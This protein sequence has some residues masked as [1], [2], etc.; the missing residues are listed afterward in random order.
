[1][2][3]KPYVDSID[4][5][6]PKPYVDPEEPAPIFVPATP[7]EEGAPVETIAEPVQ[8]NA[9]KNPE[10]VVIDQE[11]DAAARSDKSNKC[12]ATYIY[13]AVGIACLLIVGGIV[14]AIVVGISSAESNAVSTSWRYTP[15]PTAAP[16]TNFPT[17]SR[18]TSS[19]SSVVP[20]D[21]GN[22]TEAPSSN[23]TYTDTSTLAPTTP[24]RWLCDGGPPDVAQVEYRNVP[25]CL[26]VQPRST[27]MNLPVREP[28]RPLCLSGEESLS[29]P[30]MWCYRDETADTFQSY[31][32]W[33]SPCTRCGTAWRLNQVRDDDQSWF[34]SPTNDIM[35]E[36]N[37]QPPTGADSWLRWSGSS[38][39][40]DL[41]MI[42]T[43]CDPQECWVDDVSPPEPSYPY[44]DDDGQGGYSGGDY[45]GGYWGD[46]HSSQST[47]TES[48]SFSGGFGMIVVIF[49]F[50]VVGLSLLRLFLP[51]R[52]GWRRRQ[53]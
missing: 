15:Y 42:I 45:S 36:P 25:T 13:L 35:P 20:N 16:I 43:P 2:T 11:D 53:P 39:E 41:D 28:E 38:W 46:G 1:M 22:S 19:P 9:I 37:E 32:L 3:L 31:Y 6:A 30:P 29:S 34:K 47:S 5:M 21:D 23:S 52:P 7:A 33:W 10:V 17:L 49:I 27:S 51:E 50:L 40:T 24:K 48:S 8:E 44:Y 4:N 18:A 14:T 26:R 12:S